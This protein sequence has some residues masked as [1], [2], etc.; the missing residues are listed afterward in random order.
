[1][2]TETF[3]LRANIPAMSSVAA[4][5]ITPDFPLNAEPTDDNAGCQIRRDV[6]DRIVSGDDSIFDAPFS[7]RTTRVFRDKSKDYNRATIKFRSLALG[8]DFEP[9]PV[10][11]DAQGAP[12]NSHELFVDSVIMMSVFDACTSDA[13]FIFFRVMSFGTCTAGKYFV[14]FLNLERILTVTDTAEAT[15][16]IKEDGHELT[17]EQTKSAMAKCWAVLSGFTTKAPADIAQHLYRSRG[18]ALLDIVKFQKDNEGKYGFTS[19]TVGAANI[20]SYLR[21]ISDRRTAALK[22]TSGQGRPL[23]LAVSKR[24]DALIYVTIP[25]SVDHVKGH[26]LRAPPPPLPTH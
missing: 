24:D 15:K 25:T 9:L 11:D 14:K 19:E 10:W 6:I 5:P 16:L 3:S 1:M 22:I 2:T 23:A 8:K 12:S 13:R 26:H 21:A 4:A 17:D 7:L 20:P 18:N